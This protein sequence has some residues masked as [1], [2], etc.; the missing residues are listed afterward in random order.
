MRAW[1]TER[2]LGERGGRGAPLAEAAELAMRLVDLL[3]EVHAQDI[4]LPDMT[5]NHIMITPDRRPR[6]IDFEHAAARTATRASRVFTQ[7]YAGPHQMTAHQSGVVPGQS[8]DLFSLGATLLWLASGGHPA[9]LPDKHAERS[10]HQRLAELVNRIGAHMPAVRRL[11]PLILGL[12]K[13]DPA[14]RWSLSD[15]RTFLGTVDDSENLPDDGPVPAADAGIDRLISDG[16]SHVTAT[17]TPQAHRLWRART[18]ASTP[19]PFSPP[20]RA[21]PGPP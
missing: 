20:P 4:V 15:A 5:P 7:G 9:L 18:A 16:L 12:T 17:M 6:L 11:A 19:G 13:D 21:R 10:Y 2:A 1:V 14:Q 3:A 8:S